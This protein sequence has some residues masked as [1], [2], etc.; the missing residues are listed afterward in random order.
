MKVVA[1]NGS[2]NKEGNTYHAIKIVADEL[3]KEGIETE[4]IHVGNKSIRGCIAC[5][6][7]VKNK[8]EKCVLQGDEVNEWI[9][10][11]KEADG[12]ILGSPVHYSSLGATMKSFLDRAFYVTSINDG[13][14]RHKVGASV[15]A[16]RRSGGLPTFDQL[17]NYIN[18][19]EMLIPTSNYWNVIHGARPGEALQDEEGVQIMRV[20]G[21]NMAWLMK[22]VENGKGSVKEPERES[23]VYTNFIR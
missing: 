1:F 13:M 10:K 16:V 12:I 14:L 5:N 6:Q 11:M 3:R 4:V 19:S 17:N 20:L 22:L 23:K 15:V 21:K 2:P 18:Y 7:C 8:N 9:Q